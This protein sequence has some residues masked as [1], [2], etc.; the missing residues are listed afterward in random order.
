[1]VIRQAIQS[2]LSRSFKW[3][4]RFQNRSGRMIATDVV[5]LRWG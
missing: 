2:P 4:L 5:G 3:H 1:L